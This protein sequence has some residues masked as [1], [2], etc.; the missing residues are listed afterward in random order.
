LLLLPIWDQSIL[1]P[2]LLVHRAVTTA[3]CQLERNLFPLKF[4]APLCP[5]LSLSLSHTHTDKQTDRITQGEKTT[6]HELKPYKRRVYIHYNA[7]LPKTTTRDLFSVR[8]R[9]QRSSQH[10]YDMPQKQKIPSCWKRACRLQIE[11][12]KA[13]EATDLMRISLLRDLQGKTRDGWCDFGGQMKAEHEC[14]VVYSHKGNPK[15]WIP[16]QDLGESSYFAPLCVCVCVC[17]SVDGCLEKARP[18]N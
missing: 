9:T 7:A 4:Q 6:T 5:C 16:I 1:L 3:S 13:K 10:P 17:V 11:L 18:R 14:W 2:L 12:E 15:D 8:N